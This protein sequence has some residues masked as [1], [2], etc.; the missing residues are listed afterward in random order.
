MIIAVGSWRGTGTTT[1]ALLLAACLALRDDS[2]S[3]LIEADPA[4]GAIAG[5]MQLSAHTIGGLER[6]AY[7]TERVAPVDAFESVAHKGDRV[8]DM[9]FSPGQL[10]EFSRR[11]EKILRRAL[12]TSTA[13]DL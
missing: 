5:R 8:E 4:G 1:T 3:W 13:D 6:V 9:A 2:E 11:L 10:D 12:Q 7:P